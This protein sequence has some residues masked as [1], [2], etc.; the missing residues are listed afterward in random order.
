MEEKLKGLTYLGYKG[1]GDF[2]PD[3][4]KKERIEAIRDIIRPRLEK[5]KTISNGTCSSYELKHC[6]ERQIESV[7]GILKGYV[8]NGE[9][10]YAMILEDFDVRRSG[11]NA[12]FNVSAK[13]LKRLPRHPVYDYEGNVCEETTVDVWRSKAKPVYKIDIEKYRDA[14]VEY[15]KVWRKYRL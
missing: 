1:F 15:K 12:F 8:S 4:F 14:I 11:L 3:E 6:V 10:I 5:R 9:L 13:S 7:A 2:N